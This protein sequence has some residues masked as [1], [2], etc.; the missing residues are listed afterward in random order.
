MYEIHTR[1]VLEHVREYDFEKCPSTVLA[2][3]LRLL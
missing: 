3:I 1:R 2:Y